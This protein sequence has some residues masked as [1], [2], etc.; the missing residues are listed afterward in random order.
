[1]RWLF[2]LLGIASNSSASLLI[3]LALQSPRGMSS[4]QSTFINIH[5]WPF[6]AGI[7]LYATALIFYAVSLKYFPL[8]IAHPV[9]TSGAIASVAL[10]SVV[11]LGEPLRPLTLIA[12]MFI[13]FGVILL[14]FGTR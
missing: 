10:L 6:I 13:T 5:K 14:A 4:F 3:K 9:L 12:L 1:M 8:N 11:V 2:L 7:L